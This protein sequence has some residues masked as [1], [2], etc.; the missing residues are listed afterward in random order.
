MRRLYFL[1]PAIAY[2]FPVQLLLNNFRRN[3]V[4]VLCWIVL[5]AMI[6]GSFG[7]YLGI[8][9]LFLDPEYLNKVNFTSFFIIG[10]CVAGFTTAFHI[11]CYINDGHRFS[12]VGTLSRPFTKFAINNSV[13]PILF[14]GAYIYQIIGFQKNN[15]YTTGM[16]LAMNLAGL[17]T[18]YLT[19]TFI[20]FIYFWFTN[21]DIFRYV[22]CRIDEKIKSNV[23]V[24]RASA[25]KKLDIA[26]KKQVH[27]LNYIDYNMKIRKVEN[28]HFYDKATILQVFDQNHFNL[29]VIELLIL[30]I[31]MV[32]GLFKDYP[33][34]QLPAASSFMIFLSI[35]VMLA[36]AF[37]YWFGN[38]SATAALVL[39]LFLNY[40]VG[41]D[42]FT[43]RY[44]AFGLNYQRYPAEY[45]VHSLRTLNDSANIMADRKRTFSML[46]NWRN[47]FPANEKPKLVFLCVSGGGKRA[48]LWTFTALQTADSLTQGKLMENS[49]LI[50]GASGGL[51]GA[52]FFREL[53][54]REKAGEPIK[55]HSD[56][57]RRQISTDNLNPMIFSLLANDLFVGFTRFEYAG[58]LY[59]QDRGYTFEQQLNQI[60]G[61]LMDKPIA[62]Y[63][64]AELSAT[65]PMMILTPTIVNDG[66]KLYIASRPVS[67]L[68]YEI[69][70]FPEYTQQ[71]FSGVDF[72]RLFAEH[73]AEKMRFLSALRMCATFPY[74][75]PN[76]TLP[77]DPPIHIMDAG[78]SDNFG[79]SD[80]VRF[81][82]AYKDW[83]AANTSGV[84]FVSIRDS[85][86]LGNIAKREGQTII[87]AFTQPI[88]S[89]YNNFENFQD[90]TS[91]LLIGYSRS[92]FNNNIERVDIEYE[93]QDYVPI[94]Q[95]M[96]SLRKNNARASLSWRL[97]T[98]EKESIIGNISVEKNRK[99][100]E[101]L[102][103]LLNQ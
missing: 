100:I 74:I 17:I 56:F 63:D 46:E 78:I 20:F 96:D 82:Y 29:V 80:A 57:Y 67:F 3:H 9:Y 42:F 47:K 21:K 32:L 76:T 60:T 14:L 91:D 83:I 103:E 53:K 66:R 36:G 39:F 79:L 75:T 34:F 101:R 64:T 86:K 50:T 85:P 28:D 92:W 38:W 81:L 97:T 37:S 30:A 40:L 89:V 13:I 84:V 12:F 22:V 94:L 71:K 5:F 25:M 61:S 16:D 11:T 41:E 18:G 93:A 73:G 102:K 43:K 58:N 19:M 1:F 69:V 51:I 2:S 6:T 54:L 31:V 90:I 62:A 70:N 95:K 48:A 98:R 44:E 88:S 87:D 55:P 49:V 45:S 4:L 65:I 7:K 52:S 59:L 68:N 8:P 72:Q 77:T 33:A 23:K 10:L 35:F 15:E 99:A 27:V 26:R 24:T